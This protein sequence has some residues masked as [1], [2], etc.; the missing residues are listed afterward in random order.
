M[1]SWKNNKRWRDAWKDEEIIEKMEK[2]IKGRRNEWKCKERNERAKREMKEWRNYWKEEE[3]NER[4]DQTVE[5]KNDEIDERMEKLKR[6][7]WKDEEMKRWPNEWKDEQMN[8]KMNKWMKRWTNEWSF[9]LIQLYPSFNYFIVSKTFMYTFLHVNSTPF[10]SQSI[11][12]DISVNS[13]NV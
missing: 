2:W 11:G 12:N 10:C 3:M 5:W 6:N 1:N 13:V 7:E 4:N 8:E 9:D